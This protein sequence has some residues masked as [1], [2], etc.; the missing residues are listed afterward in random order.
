M[1]V[2]FA[3]L[4]TGLGALAGDFSTAAGAGF[5]F[6]SD[7]WG[8]ASA[9]AGVVPRVGAVGFTVRDGLVA[10]TDVAVVGAGGFSERAAGGL[11]AADGAGFPAGLAAAVDLAIALSGVADFS[12]AA[13][14]FGGRGAAATVDFA[15][16]ASLAFP[17]A[18]T[19]STAFTSVVFISIYSNPIPKICVPT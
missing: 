14:A 1:V 5:G 19:F 11:A 4:V 7:F 15:E 13:G 16:G 2:G 10:A 8:G 12:A 17:A 9:D 18:L 3:V 6:L